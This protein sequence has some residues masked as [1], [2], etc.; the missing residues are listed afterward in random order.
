M[1]KEFCIY[2]AFAI[3]DVKDSSSDDTQWLGTVTGLVA[4]THKDLQGDIL[5]HNFIKGT[6]KDLGTNRTVF[7]NH[8]S[9]QDPIAKVL[10]AKTK[11][12]EE[13]SSSEMLDEKDTHLLFQP[14]DL[15]EFLQQILPVQ[16]LYLQYMRLYPRQTHILK[17][18]PRWKTYLKYPL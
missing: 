15:P 2:K 1:R 4:T 6:T 18:I 9:E 3:T 8:R 11:R 10:D 13:K 16:D 5:T 7:Y 14:S 12:L 17:E